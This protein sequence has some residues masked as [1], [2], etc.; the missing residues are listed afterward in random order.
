MFIILVFGRW[1]GYDNVFRFI[2]CYVICLMVVWVI[3]DFV[4]RGEKCFKKI[5]NWEGIEFF[6]SFLKRIEV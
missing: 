5:R 1:N 3:K 4:L 6:L 2:F